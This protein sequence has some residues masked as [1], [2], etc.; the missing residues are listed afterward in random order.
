MFTGISDHCG[1]I[2]HINHDNSALSVWIECNFVDMEPGESISVDGIC[3]TV[4]EQQP[5]LFR[6]DISSETCRLTIAERYK[7]GQ[8][9]NIE[10]ALRASDRLGGHFV[11]GHI[12]QLASVASIN[13]QGGFTEM[14]F[15][16]IDTV[17]AKKFLIKKGCITING[18]SLTI[19]E[20]FAD[21]FAVMLIPHTLE[22]TNL[23]SLNTMDQVNI[24]FDWMVKI[25]SQQIESIQQNLVVR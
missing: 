6:C 20:V 22:R 17:L 13:M 18:V 25:V 15:N 16:N 5:K 19:N 2:K 3:L 23:K 21:G 24:E 7:P 1:I 12:D 11:T 4:V 10:R 9:V 8:L 14:R